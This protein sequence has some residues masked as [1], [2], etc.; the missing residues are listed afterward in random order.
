MATAAET[1]DHIVIGGGSA[2]CVV[3]GRLGGDAGR[4]VLVLEAGDNGDDWL[5]NIPFGV[6]KIWNL[7]KF[8][9][10]YQ[11]EPEPHVDNRSIYHPRG[12]TLGGSAAINMM[13]YVRGNAGDY[14]RWAQKG[15]SDWS[16][17]KVLP[18]FKKT[19]SWQQGADTWRGS[20]GPMQIR[21]TDA[22]HDPLL[23][24]WLAAGESA[25]Y[26]TTPDFNGEK[27]D[28]LT[29]AQLNIG[30]GRR[31]H[32]ANT[33]LR[34]AMRKGN[35]KVV[36]G[37]LVHRLILDSSRVSGVEYSVD[38]DTVTV[39]STNEVVLSAG[40]FN[41]PQVLMRSGIGPAD[42]LR[43]LG[44]EVLFD[45]PEIGGNLQD[46]P[47]LALEFELLG[48]TPF[49]DN[50]RY[51]RLALNMLRAHLFKSGPC[52]EPLA[53]GTG[54]ARS[55]PDLDIP[56]LQFFFRR[57]SASARPWFPGVLPKGPTAFGIGVCHLRP[58]SRGTV[59]LTSSDPNVQPRILNNFLSTP[60]D[61]DTLREAVR[62]V[63]NIAM[64]PAFNEVRGNE[65]MPG[66]AVRNDDEI[67]AFIRQTLATVFHPCGTCRIGADPQSVVDPQLKMRGIENL[68][69]IDASVFPDIVGGNINACTMMVAE[70]GADFMLAA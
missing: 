36:T 9:W 43:D 18:Y 6:A 69:I 32:S 51:D 65:L 19:E 35:I 22:A 54:F 55:R 23:D 49:Q 28:G 62:I 5:I 21:Y 38:G 30:G 42:H 37:A 44:I 52:M 4:K 57:F 25:G 14:D 27:Q 40:A 3:A 31:A 61:R 7:P 16:Y 17:E 47:S 59:R 46:H 24:R 41:S 33:L 70:K 15:L 26:G 50:L 2:G 58:E 66:T 45:Q 63:R 56:D 34:P 1:F 67:D 8:N 60:G 12:K 29:R 39:T 11:S 13:A 48:P 53:F 64:Q 20:D 10:S 68:R